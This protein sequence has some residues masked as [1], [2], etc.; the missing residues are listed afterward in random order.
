MSSHRL[1]RSMYSRS[2]RT[3]SSK[4]LM[5]LRPLTCH[6]HVMPGLERELSLVPQ[7]V[8]LELVP[9]RGSRADEA[10]VALQHAPELRQLVQAVLAQEAAERGDAGIAP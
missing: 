9:E 6:R 10:H 8:A 5:R 3:H 4:L 2:S 1:Q 7:L